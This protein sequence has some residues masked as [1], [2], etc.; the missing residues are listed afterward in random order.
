MLNQ[1]QTDKA[2]RVSTG[3]S[4]E[5]G[6]HRMA[7]EWTENGTT[8]SGVYIPRRDTSSLLNSLAGGRIFPGLHYHAAFTVKEENG[9]YQIAFKSSDATTISI[10]AK[11]SDHFNSNSIFQNLANASAFFEGGAVGYSPDGNNFE[12][13]QLNINNWKVE[14]LEVTAVQSS[15]FENENIF[16][17]GSVIFDNALLMRQI[18]HSGTRLGKK[19][20]ACNNSINNYF[21]LPFL[22]I[23][24]YHH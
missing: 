21:C 18:K 10:D 22:L 2:K 1:T 9:H 8:K 6:A 20:T 4:S 5:N 16:P 23:V 13:L 14:P 15:F 7:V 3:I 11:E 24:K 17:K 12:G 19:T